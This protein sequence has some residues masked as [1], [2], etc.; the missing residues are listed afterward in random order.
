[1]LTSKEPVRVKKYSIHYSKQDEVNEKVQKTLKLGIIET[2]TSDYN[3]PIVIV[4]KK[5]NRKRFCIDF[6]RL[7]SV[8]NFDTKPMSSDEDIW[9]KLYQDNLFSK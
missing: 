4:R 6:R 3:S 1:M 8:T 5:Y 9:T 7:N 2:A